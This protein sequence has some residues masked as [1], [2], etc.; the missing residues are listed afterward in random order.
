MRSF[1]AILVLAT[2]ISIAGCSK[3]ASSHK[4]TTAPSAS[5]AAP[6]PSLATPEPSGSAKPYTG[7]AGAIRGTVRVVGDAP[8]VLDDVL[9]KIPDECAGARNVYGTLFRKGPGGEAA[10]VLVTVT[11]YEHFV[12]P[13]ADHVQ[14]VGKDC[15]WNTRT[16]G[17][18]M[19]QYIEVIA[20]DPKGYVPNLIGMPTPANMIP[21]PGGAAAR[22]KPERPGRHGLNDLAHLFAYADVFVVKFSTLDVTGT[23]GVFEIAGVPAGTA[24]VSALLPAA[25]LVAQQKVTVQANTTTTVQFAL[26]FD[27]AKYQQQRKE[28]LSPHSSAQ[29]GTVPSAQ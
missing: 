16:I 28:S 17:M 4:D 1:A 8:P 24:T 5:V 7:P 10:D 20:K 26:T 6:A 13:A 19:G 2:A 12:P 25:M 15:A 29:V 22:L 9:R 3:R 18:T 11:D 21:V 23:D 14:V 27:E